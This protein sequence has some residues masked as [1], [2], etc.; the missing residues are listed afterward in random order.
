[1]LNRMGLLTGAGPQNP[2]DRK[3]WLMEHQPYSIRVGDK[4]V[5]YDR[6]DVLGGL[7]SIPA[8]IVDATTNVP[9][10]QTYSD[11]I[12]SGWGAGPVVQGSS[13]AARGCW[14]CWR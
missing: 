7:L 11:M 9:E 3:V 1:M 10:D 6:Y 5:R 12:L 4:W 8:T 13:R 2:T 14:A